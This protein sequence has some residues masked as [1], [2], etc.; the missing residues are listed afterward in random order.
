MA[1]DEPFGDGTKARIH[2]VLVI[3]FSL[4]PVDWR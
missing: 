1:L 3:V 4:L 2:A